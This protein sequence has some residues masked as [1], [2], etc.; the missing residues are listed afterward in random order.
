MTDQ[1]YILL[2]RKIRDLTGLDLDDYKPQQMQ[3]RLT[4]LIAALSISVAEYCK[5]I[6]TDDELLKKLKKFITINVSEFFRDADYFDVLK[7]KVLPDFLK[8]NNRISVWSAGCSHG[9]EPYSI[10]MLLEDLAPGQPYRILGTDLDDDIL[11][12]AKNGGPYTD[13]DVSG[14]NPKFLLKYFTKE[15]DGYYLTDE[16]KR[17]VEFKRH[18]LL[19]DSFERGFDI[20]LCRNVVIYFSDEAKAKLYKGFCDS[21]KDGGVLFIGATEALINASE[22]GLDK[23]QNCF[24]KKGV[25]SSKVSGSASAARV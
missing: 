19:K 23:I 7:T 10:A 12:K 15:K 2:T 5:R 4:G 21:L 3:R 9:G 25:A 1:E 16:I 13:G 14:V 8:G 17:K 24:Y 22:L 20:L 11:A 6:E 18:N